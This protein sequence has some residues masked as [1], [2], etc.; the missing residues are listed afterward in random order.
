MNLLR[1]LLVPIDFSPQSREA[2]SCAVALARRTGA[3][4]ILLHA[5]EHPS[6]FGPI[7]APALVTDAI[8]TEEAALL[9]QARLEMQH[10]VLELTNREDPGIEQDLW[11][12]EPSEVIL[13]VARARDVGMIV[14]GTHGRRGLSH[15][16]VGS[17]AER[18]LRRAPCPVMTVPAPGAEAR[19]A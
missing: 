16:M 6:F 18:V 12:G 4:L 15:L 10:A 7:D 2:L 14:M 9:E 11:M 1:S 19:A 5:V 3:K 8:R 17:V 13:E